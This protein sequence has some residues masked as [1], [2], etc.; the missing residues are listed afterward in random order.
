M[1]LNDPEAQR[2][3]EQALEMSDTPNPV[4]CTAKRCVGAYFP[5]NEQF[6]KRKIYETPIFLVGKS[7]ISYTSDVLWQISTC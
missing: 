6:A 4:P 3:F 2:C 7:T 5:V 1:I